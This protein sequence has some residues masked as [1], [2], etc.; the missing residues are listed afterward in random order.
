MYHTSQWACSECSVTKSDEVY[1][2]SDACR[3]EQELCSNPVERY[4]VCLETFG[5]RHVS[6]LT[7]A[8][9]L[10]EAYSNDIDQDINLDEAVS[11]MTTLAPLIA[12]RHDLSSS[13]LV[14]ADRLMTSSTLHHDM[15]P[16]IMNL[17]Q[18]LL[19]IVRPAIEAQR[20]WDI[21]HALEEYYDELID[22]LN[23]LVT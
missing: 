6:T 22:T 2:S 12:A 23:Q 4:N 11:Q 3:V 15:I 17:V 14:T 21:P 19:L 7:S 10:F 20:T 5:W 16:Q 8:I 13:F 9:A 18:E 1:A